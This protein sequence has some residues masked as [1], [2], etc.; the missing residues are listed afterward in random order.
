M[1]NIAGSPH[2]AFASPRPV[3]TTWSPEEITV[4]GALGNGM[5]AS[6]MSRS[7]SPELRPSPDMSNLTL[8][9]VFSGLIFR[10][11]I[12]QSRVPGPAFVK[13]KAN[14][15]GSLSLP[16]SSKYWFQPP[17]KRAALGSTIKGRN[18]DPGNCNRFFHVL[19]SMYQK[20]VC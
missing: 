17:I 12:L 1:E 7:C 5:L 13:S 18:G 19:V 10:P 20:Q 2:C 3:S 15:Q 11:D 4:L 9:P 8:L 6:R 14:L 16:L